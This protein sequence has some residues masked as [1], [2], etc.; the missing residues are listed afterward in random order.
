MLTLQ[1]FEASDTVQACARAGTQTDQAPITRLLNLK[2][3]AS[4]SL[5]ANQWICGAAEAQRPAFAQS[6]GNNRVLE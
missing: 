2:L 4:V 6:N 5:Q 1:R 3:E